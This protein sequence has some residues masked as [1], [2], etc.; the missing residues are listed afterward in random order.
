MVV[1]R[2]LHQE[3]AGPGTWSSISD[4]RE[5][6]HWLTPQSDDCYLFTCKMLSVEQGIPLNGRINIDLINPQKLNSVTYIAP[7]ISGEAAS[8]LYAS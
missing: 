2:T 4:Y 8:Q 1:R 3:S 7:K 6:V 5:N